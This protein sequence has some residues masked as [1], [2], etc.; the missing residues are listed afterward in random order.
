MPIGYNSIAS[1]Q[2]D[3]VMCTAAMVPDAPAKLD[4]QSGYGGQPSTT[5]ATVKN[6]FP[7]TY[8]FQTY[9]GSI[10]LEMAPK[11]LLMLKAWITDRL[12]T[13]F[14]FT[15]STSQG[16]SQT[17]SDVYWNSMTI[18][19]GEDNFITLS[20]DITALTL[21]KASSA[22]A[23]IDMREKVENVASDSYPHLNE[24]VRFADPDYN[25][26]PYYQGVVTVGVVPVV[27]ELAGWSAT[28][29]QELTFDYKCEGNAT[30]DSPAY[31]TASPLEGQIEIEHPA[32]EGT[33]IPTFEID[34]FAALGILFKEC[35]LISADEGIQG[36]DGVN[37]ITASY[38]VYE[39][40]RHSRFQSILQIVGLCF[41]CRRRHQLHFI[42]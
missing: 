11:N 5:A 9:T 7:R 29:S 15:I 33:F 17:Y 22:T 32:I 28:F 19:V 35:E 36:M 10:D 1:I 2:G 14:T 12:M 37:S 8:D 4:S 30:P 42:L 24:V 26:L 25:P 6:G 31:V 38:F 18:S 23:Y 13:G 21:V 3:F 16:N 20:I 40:N 41:I 39:I 34:Q 27:L